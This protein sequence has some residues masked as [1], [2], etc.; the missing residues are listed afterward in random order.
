MNF[1]I[2]DVKWE[3]VIIATDADLDGCHIRALL[4]QFFIMYMPQLVQDGRLYSTVP[5]L[6]GLK[7]KNKTV[8]FKDKIDYT[9]YIQSE[10]TKNNSVTTLK[11][12]PLTNSQ[13]LKLMVDNMYYTYEMSIIQNRYAIDPYLLETLLINRNKSIK[14]LAQD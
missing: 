2:D 1:N 9:K 11:G 13:I 8:Y 10:F 12:K 6:Y 5:P 3:K 14:E 7:K 4:L